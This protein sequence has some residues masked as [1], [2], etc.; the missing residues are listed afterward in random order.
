[1]KLLVNNNYQERCADI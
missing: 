1:L